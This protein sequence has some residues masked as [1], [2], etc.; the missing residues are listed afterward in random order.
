MQHQYNYGGIQ[1]DIRS[2]RMKKICKTCKC[3]VLGYVMKVSLRTVIHSDNACPVS[4]NNPFKGT[5]A[6]TVYNSSYNF[7]LTQLRILVERGTSIRKDDYEAQA[8]RTKMSCKVVTQSKV[9]Q[10]VA[11][12]HNFRIDKDKPPLDAIRLNVDGSLDARD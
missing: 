10:A 5:Q 8:L 4:N 1:P 2:I 11:R 7:H 12:L 3:F 6:T 9:I